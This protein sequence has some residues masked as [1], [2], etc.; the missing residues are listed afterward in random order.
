MQYM[1]AGVIRDLI[2]NSYF[3]TLDK[4]D[5]L[6]YNNNNSIMLLQIR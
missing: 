1:I 4:A 5:N 2:M 3:R 6:C